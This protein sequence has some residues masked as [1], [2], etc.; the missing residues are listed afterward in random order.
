MPAAD[1]GWEIRPFTAADRP[2]VEELLD[3]D[4]DRLWTAQGHRLHGEALDGAR[5]RRTLVAERNGRV[6][7]AA[8]VASNRIHPGRY[9]LAVEVA[10]GSRRQGLGRTLVELARPLAP[11]PLPLSGKLRPADPGGR[12]LLAALG[13]RTYQRCPG[14]CPDPTEPSVRAWVAGTLVPPD[15]VLPLGELSLV[16][17]AELWVR[18]YRWVHQDWSPAAEGPLREL[19]PELVADAEPELSTI[20]VRH[21]Q[22]IAV[23]WVFDAPDSSAEIVSE[24]TERSVPGGVAAVAAGLARSLSLLAERGVRRAE[25]DGHDSDPHLAVVLGGFPP[26]PREP[27]DLVELAPAAGAHRSVAR[28]Q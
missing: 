22:V 7:G 12:G 10:A 19:A 9:N 17:R 16:E 1:P 23:S 6:V 8:T 2:G 24:T 28:Q 11:E 18:Q 13:G 26:V 14:L 20:T 27:L 25:I 21:S 4:A 15:A 5:W 3:A